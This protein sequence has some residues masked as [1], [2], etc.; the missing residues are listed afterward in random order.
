MKIITELWMFQVAE[1]SPQHLADSRVNDLPPED[2]RIVQLT[3]IHEPYDLLHDLR[4][5]LANDGAAEYS[6]GF[7]LRL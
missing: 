1:R 4:G 5:E 2:G 7:V 6:S 3:A